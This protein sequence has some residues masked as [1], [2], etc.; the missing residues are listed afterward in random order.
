[1]KAVIITTDGGKRVTEFEFGNALKPLQ[2]AVGG[3]IELIPL[4][5]LV[6]DMWVNDEGKL[7][8]FAP[9]FLATELWAK[10]NLNA[11]LL[12]GDVIITGPSDEQGETLG[13]TD[14]QVGF[15]LAL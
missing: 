1:M 12:Y 2:E 11:E 9:N 5:H 3:L 6:A 8:D 14:E 10:E 4:H 13:L 7:H 15:L